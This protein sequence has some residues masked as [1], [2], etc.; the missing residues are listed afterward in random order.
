MSVKKDGVAALNWKKTWMSTV[1]GK[2]SGFV[3]R[4]AV[5]YAALFILLGIQMPFF[6]VWLE[7]KGLDPS[8]IGIVLAVPTLSRLIALP[9]VTRE[10]DRRDA[11]R[12][13]LILACLAAVVGYIAVGL[14][15]GA[16]AILIAFAA[17]S[18]ASTVM[19]PLSET[20]ALRGLMS[21]G[22]AY[23]PVRLWGSFA[24]IAG[25]LAAGFASDF[26][27]AGDLIWLIVAA[28]VLLALTSL[29]LGPLPP[30]A[31]VQTAV[32][33]RQSLLR[34][35]AFVYVILASSLIQASHAMF[36]GFS[37]VQWRA[38]GM[39]GSVIA[40]LWALGVAAEIVLFAL[41]S[42]LPP[43]LQPTL[44]L[45]VGACGAAMRWIG[46][47][48]DP[49]PLALVALQLL[50]A[51]S[52]GATHIG[53]LM[54][55]AAR[56]PSSQAATAQGYLAMA[57]G[58][59]MAASSAA[60]GVLYDAVGSGAYVAMALTALAGGACGLIARRMGNNPAR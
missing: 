37:A 41:H 2:S 30:S 16:V 58:I 59:A 53:T 55:V 31:V 26:I 29:T 35:R 17:T 43:F 21:R 22:R 27:A 32:S 14:S 13:C 46:M 45:L 12:A 6:P 57:T 33:L 39:D 54:F 9:P 18:L 47:A 38:N 42:R 1:Q 5:L 34:D 52:F 19:M 40:T 10:A 36:Y 8:V 15:S 28:S 50:H 25:N 4:V 3:P 44:M 48:L 60:S 20:Y 49:A 51:I 23:G 56:A 24:F 7:A 11:V